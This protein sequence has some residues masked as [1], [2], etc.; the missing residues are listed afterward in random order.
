MG[1]YAPLKREKYLDAQGND[2]QITKRR[3]CDISIGE[4]VVLREEFIV[5]PVS[6]PL[7][8]VGKLMRQG[9]QLGERNGQLQMWNESKT[10]PAY[11]KRHSLCIGGI[12]RAVQAE[13][14][15]RGECIEV[16]LLPQLQKLRKGWTQ[17]GD[18]VW[19]VKVHGM[20]FTDVSSGLP[21]ADVDMRTTLILRGNTWVV[22]EYCEKLTNL[23]NVSGFIEDLEQPTD[24]ITIAHKGYSAP[25]GIG[26]EVETKPEAEN[27]LQEPSSSSRPS[28]TGAKA[29]SA[30][31]LARA[32]KKMKTGLKHSSVPVLEPNV[33]SAPGDLPQPPHDAVVEMAVEG[34]LRDDYEPEAVRELGDMEVEVNGILLTEDDTLATLRQ[35]CE[36][37]GIGKSG[38]KAT[39]LKRLKQHMKKQEQFADKRMRSEV[40]AEEKRK[41][42]A[43]PSVKEP[44]P[45]EMAEHSMTHYPFQS[46][47]KF[48]ASVKSRVDRHE[49]SEDSSRAL[50]QV[51][52]DFCYTSRDPE[53]AGLGVKADSKAVK[54]C[55]LVLH[56]RDSKM[57]HAIPTPMK[58]GKW[59]DTLVA[60]V[61]RFL[62]FLGYTEVIFKTDGEPTPLLLQQKV[63]QQRLKYGARTVLQNSPRGDHQANGAVEN[64]VQSIRQQ[65]NIFLAEL[66]D[67]LK[68]KVGTHDA[69]HSWAWMHSAWIHN[70]YHVIQGLTPM[71]RASGGGVYRGR[72]V[73]FG[74][75]V[76]AYMK[77]QNKGNPAWVKSVWLGKVGSSDMH[78]VSTMGA[79]KHGGGL[80]LTRSVRRMVESEKWVARMVQSIKG[81]PW[82]YPGYLGGHLG[83]GRPK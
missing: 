35:A 74:E 81:H 58:G 83:F 46:W 36:K 63:Q 62:S 78:L 28:E 70:R 42:L 71:E 39:V 52:A 40:P 72:I 21:N 18:F 57:V 55:C 9:W 3:V 50:P 29:T 48:C 17:V 80:V 41:P 20:N 44:T 24:I 34:A 73:D 11:Y 79:G 5:A 1:S 7:L 30:E 51:S 66:E 37:C 67:R 16:S 26:L 60:E 2:L 65:C 12:I 59:M 53:K 49:R 38:G 76:L 77:V 61:C 45:Q 33:V 22:I 43:P 68:C 69:I 31:D 23:A 56:D 4:N 27:I 75:C 19:A 6:Q 15:Y 32:A 47:C 82:D 25:L 64:A 14:V 8:A 54:L 10:L 13:D